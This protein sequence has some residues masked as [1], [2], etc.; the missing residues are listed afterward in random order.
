MRFL[1][2]LFV[3]ALFFTISSYAQSEKKGCAKEKECVVK[4]CEDD[5]SEVKAHVK[6]EEKHTPVSTK[7]TKKVPTAGGKAVIKE[8]VKKD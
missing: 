1:P 7:K 2:F 5:G 4:T 6:G 8:E 3:F